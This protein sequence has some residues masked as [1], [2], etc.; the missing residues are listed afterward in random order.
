MNVQNLSF[1]CWDIISE[2]LRVAYKGYLAVIVQFYIHKGSEV[3]TLVQNRIR[4]GSITV[5]KAYLLC[6]F[7]RGF[8]NA[9]HQLF[10][11]SC[12]L[13]FF[14]KS[15]IC[16][17][18]VEKRRLSGSLITSLQLQKIMSSSSVGFP[19]TPWTDLFPGLAKYLYYAIHRY[20]NKTSYFW[21]SIYSVLPKEI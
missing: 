12:S 9:V 13:S 10:E 7:Q 5:T 15:S 6:W 17:R 2:D 20:T 19:V 3:I 11:L 21:G 18:L 1:L 14:S 16:D 8:Q 4:C